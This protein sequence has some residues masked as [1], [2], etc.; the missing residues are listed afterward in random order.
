MTPKQ[1]SSTRWPP[2]VHLI[3]RVIRNLF[4]AL[5]GSYA[6]SLTGFLV[7]RAISGD[8]LSLVAILNSYVHL[9]L[10]LSP[11]ALIPALMLRNRLLLALLALPILAFVIDYGG[12]FIPR[13][14]VHA[15]DQTEFRLLTYNLLR[16]NLNTD[17]TTAIIRESGA[18]VVALQEL[19]P[20]QAE[21]FDGSLRDLYPY[22][23]FHPQ[24]DFSG[25]GVLSRYPIRSDEFWQIHLGHQRIELEI[26]GQRIALYNAHPIHPFIGGFPNFYQPGDRASEIEVLLNR[27]AAESIPVLL[28]GDFNLS[29]QEAL[30]QQISARF[31]DAYRQMG[32]GM[33]FTYPNMGILLA[34]IDYVFHSAAFTPLEARVLPDGGGSDHLPLWVRLGLNGN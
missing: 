8:A 16:S 3:A 9:L 25:Q 19:T 23:A 2:A 1:T 22:Q 30:Y 5:I 33:G 34:R 20:L 11:L 28:V 4:Q 6:L 21:A 18:D 13:S 32:W 29:D 31:S 7:L 10:I 15:A 17:A 27:T 12:Q 24:E 14:A 26:E